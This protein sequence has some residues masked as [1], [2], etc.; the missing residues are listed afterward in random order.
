MKQKNCES[1][2]KTNVYIFGQKKRKN[3]LKYTTEKH[4]FV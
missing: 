1:F 2:E 4:F 3:E